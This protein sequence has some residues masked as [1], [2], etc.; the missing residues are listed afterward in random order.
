MYRKAVELESDLVYVSTANEQ[1]ASVPYLIA[2]DHSTRQALR[3]AMHH[4]SDQTQRPATQEHACLVSR[5]Q[6]LES[7]KRVE[8]TCTLHVLLH[9]TGR[10]CHAVMRVDPD[11]LAL[12]D[13]RP[14]CPASSC[15]ACS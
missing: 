14:A 5:D 15:S 6:V 9:N 13:Q 3:N 4:V 2:L 12:V 11:P 7:W 10:R 8:L 1:L